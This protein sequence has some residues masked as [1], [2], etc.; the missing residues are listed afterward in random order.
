GRLAGVTVTGVSGPAADRALEVAGLETGSVLREAAVDAALDRISRLSQ[1]AVVA[2]GEGW[3]IEP[4]PD[5]PRLALHLEAPSGS[6]GLRFTQPPGYAPYN[7]ID[8]VAPWIGVGA[9]LNDRVSYN[10][11]DLYAGGT[12]GTASKATRFALGARRPFGRGGPV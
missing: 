11:L 7:R 3:G 10:H 12:Y 4:T 5:G 2:E 6:V 8:G 9:R 1:G